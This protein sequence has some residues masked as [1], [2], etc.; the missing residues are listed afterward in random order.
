MPMIRYGRT[1]LVLLA[2][3]A[4]L[5][6]SDASEPNVDPCLLQQEIYV[7]TSEPPR[8]TWEPTCR[9]AILYVRPEAG[10]SYTW[11]IQADTNHIESGITYGE[12]PAEGII[13]EVGPADLTPGTNYVVTIVRRHGRGAN[14]LVAV[15]ATLFSVGLS[16]PPAVA[17]AAP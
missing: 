15:A 17:G 5:G 13:D 1:G 8:F 4:V 10:G 14:D 12:A 2:V 7:L 11:W 9:M 3:T 6:C 16:K